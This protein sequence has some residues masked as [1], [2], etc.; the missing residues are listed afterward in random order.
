VQVQ[1]NLTISKVEREGKPI[2]DFFLF[3]KQVTIDRNTQ[4]VLIASL[5]T[6]KFIQNFFF[7]NL[8]KKK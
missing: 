8:K 3:L 4:F 6:Y 2:K 7:L 5:A 1:F